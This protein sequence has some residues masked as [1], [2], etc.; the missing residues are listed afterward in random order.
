M[1]SQGDSVS[2]DGRDSCVKR[3]N[4]STWCRLKYGKGEDPFYDALGAPYVMHVMEGFHVAAMGHT[5]IGVG[6]GVGIQHIWPFS[7][8]S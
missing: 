3:Q 2:S 5:W 1:A 7:M 6:H 8:C 4:P